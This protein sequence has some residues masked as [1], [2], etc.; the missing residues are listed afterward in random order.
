LST[1]FVRGILRPI[2]EVA[3]VV[4]G[5]LFYFMKDRRVFELSKHFQHQILWLPHE[6]TCEVFNQIYLYCL[7]FI[8]NP[9]KLYVC[10]D[11]KLWHVDIAPKDIKIINI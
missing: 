4:D 3:I 8:T 11:G 9:P 2:K 1:T 10:S 5:G 6:V 7:G